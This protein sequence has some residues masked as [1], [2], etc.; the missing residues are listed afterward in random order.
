MHEGC[1]QSNF[2]DF[3]ELLF[4]DIG[5][6]TSDS[7]RLN[8]AHSSTFNVNHTSSYGHI[9]RAE[10]SASTMHLHSVWLICYIFELFNQISGPV[11]SYKSHLARILLQS[12]GNAGF[13]H[14]SSATS[15]LLGQTG[16]LSCNPSAVSLS[17]GFNSCL[18]LPAKLQVPSR[19]Q[20]NSPGQTQPDA[21]SYLK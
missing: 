21:Q 8:I 9:L 2:V 5:N 1:S 7:A 14:L 15:N 19:T 16:L 18:V 12:H 20:V 3:R 6:R 11:S 10:N 13:N 4:S 17:V